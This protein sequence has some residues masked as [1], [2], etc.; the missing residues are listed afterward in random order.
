MF[1]V[2]EDNLPDIMPQF[3]GGAHLQV[4]VFD[5]S[6]RK[7]LAVGQVAAIDNQIDT[8]T[9][10][11]KIR[12]QFENK[13]NALFPNQFVNVQLLVKTLKD[14]ITVPT[15]AI[16]RGS[17][18]ATT[19]GALGTFVYL[20]DDNNVVSVRQIVVG[21]SFVDSHSV[22]MTSVETG[23]SSGDHVVT[24]GADRLRAGLHVNVTTLD[25]KPLAPAAPAEGAPGQ[26]G[27]RQHR[28]QG[29]PPG[30]NRQ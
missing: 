26:N 6:N 17:P 15:A 24:D 22:S 13:D 4:T 16:Q 2:P 19:G 7:Q 21:P 28:G 8:T 29:R 23:L 10:T 11:V 14:A 9:G 25:G 12:A 20:V 27:Q 5:R 3:T 1:S 30:G 18:G